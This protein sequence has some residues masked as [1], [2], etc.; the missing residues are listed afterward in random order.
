MSATVLIALFSFV[1]CFVFLIFFEKKMSLFAKN[2]RF[3]AVS[4]AAVYSLS[5]IKILSVLC[6]SCSESLLETKK[7]KQT[8]PILE[9]VIHNNSKL[10]KKRDHKAT[11]IL[12]ALNF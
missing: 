12:F 1:F 9:E 6:M 2:E 7:H 10:K 4:N 5:E 3:F 8:K 11:F